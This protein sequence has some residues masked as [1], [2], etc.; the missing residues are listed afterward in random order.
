[1][2]N[3]GLLVTDTDSDR[4]GSDR[5]GSGSQRVQ[6]T[7]RNSNLLTQKPLTIHICNKWQL[8]NDFK[9]KKKKGT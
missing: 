5:F 2:L 9:K 1:M 8:K 4:I 3:G 6:Q 7:A